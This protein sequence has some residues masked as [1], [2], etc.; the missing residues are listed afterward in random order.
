MVDG[1]T[2]TVADLQ[3]GFVEPHSQAAL[4]KALGQWPYKIVLVF[5]GVADKDIPLAIRGEGAG[6]LSIPVTLRFLSRVAVGRQDAPPTPIIRGDIFNQGTA[7]Q[8]VQ[9]KK[10][11]FFVDTL[12]MRKQPEVFSFRSGQSRR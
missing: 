11:F 4:L 1:L 6:G 5:A 10:E 2:Q 7:I 8:I 9:K 3:R 12:G